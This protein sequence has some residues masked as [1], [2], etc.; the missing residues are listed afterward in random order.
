M[1]EE[2]STKGSDILDVKGSEQGQ[3]A[4]VSV[5][6]AADCDSGSAG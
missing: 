1:V 5:H 6:S 2:F 4:G 3:R